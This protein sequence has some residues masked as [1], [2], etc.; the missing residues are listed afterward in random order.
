MVKLPNSQV[1]FQI[2]S[3]VNKQC[4]NKS[5]II[6]LKLGSFS[7]HEFLFAKKITQDAYNHITP[8][9]THNPPNYTK[10]FNSQKANKLTCLT[11]QIDI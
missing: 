2:I 5:T 8:L 11:E 3:P 6:V 9:A 4:D 7:T 10:K 1:M